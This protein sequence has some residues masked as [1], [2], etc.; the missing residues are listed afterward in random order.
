MNRV[1]S[2][3]NTSFLFADPFSWS[4]NA[5]PEELWLGGT[6]TGPYKGRGLVNV[7]SLL[8]GRDNI[9][10]PP[11]RIDSAGEIAWKI[12]THKN[13]FETINSQYL[14]AVR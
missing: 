4:T 13:H 8:E 1:A 3:Q 9:L 12:R 7:Q 11:W 14:N 10:T 2:K 6:T 5:A